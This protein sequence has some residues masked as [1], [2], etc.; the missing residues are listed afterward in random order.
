MTL[1]QKLASKHLITDPQS[2]PSAKLNRQSSASEGES[3]DWT[4]ETC[5]D[6]DPEGNTILCSTICTLILIVFVFVG[7]DTDSISTTSKT[8]TTT[9]T[10]VKTTKE[11]EKPSPA[12]QAVR[13]PST[14]KIDAHTA[15][16][17]NYKV[18]KPSGKKHSFGKTK[19]A[20]ISRRFIQDEQENLK[21][22][23]F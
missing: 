19:L 4:W 16:W 10:S 11:V 12:P 21:I 3:S 5:S 2:R 13:S 14:F 23:N 1:G 7:V 18:D 6:S 8:T 22:Q 17:L 9:S 20:R 15:K